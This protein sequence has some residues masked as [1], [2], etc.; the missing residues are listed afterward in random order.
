[1]MTMMMM[2][3]IVFLPVLFDSSRN[4]VCCCW[5]WFSSVPVA[6]QYQVDWIKTITKTTRLFHSHS[7]TMAVPTIPFN[8][9]TVSIK[10]QND[11]KIIPT[12]QP[13][14]EHELNQLVVCHIERGAGPNSFTFSSYLL[15][16]SLLIRKK[17]YRSPKLPL[18]SAHGWPPFQRIT[19]NQNRR[20]W[21][22]ARDRSSSIGAT[23]LPGSFSATLLVASPM[24]RTPFFICFISRILCF[25][26][27]LIVAKK[28]PK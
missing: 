20:Q 26:Y 5:Y 9:N 13:Q 10:M 4:T 16:I 12:P 6:L 8:F 1:M 28:Y 23:H 18:Q 17:N 11:S 21:A 24:L 27:L 7:I 25:R 19:E 2:V 3:M 15:E 14:Q 22:D